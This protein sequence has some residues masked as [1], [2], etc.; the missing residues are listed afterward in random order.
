MQLKV[1]IVPHSS[2]R[3]NVN[4]QGFKATFVAGKSQCM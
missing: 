2:A 1:E 4:G 3:D